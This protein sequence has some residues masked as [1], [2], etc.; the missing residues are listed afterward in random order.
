[1]QERSI[2]EIQDLFA[3][4]ASTR[5]LSRLV[6][7]YRGDSRLGVQKVCDVAT[8][9]LDA[10]RAERRRTAGLYATE[11]RLRERGCFAIAGVD[12]V[13]RGALAGPLTVCAV[14]LPDTPLIEGLDDS[15]RLTP[16]RREFLAEQIR[17]TATAFAVAHTPADEIDS[18]GITA[19]L[20]SAIVRAVASLPV[21]IDHLLLDG[22]P[23]RLF[24]HET[25][26]V[27]GDSK[28]A[29]I[30]AASIVAKVTRDAMMVDY[31]AQFPGY[32][33]AVNKG[34]STSDHMDALSSLGPCSLHRRSF[35]PGGGTA[36][37]F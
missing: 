2:P 28:V 22:L 3:Q 30:A 19:A 7:E 33:F 31:D 6:K 11:R 8:A 10:A 36:R 12:E 16:A 1:M 29:A 21:D 26:V 9:R 4:A 15:K 14:I 34:Y 37:L 27:K 24:D 5:E 23:L 13:G 17:E 35:S 32:G 25:A 18:M 20:K